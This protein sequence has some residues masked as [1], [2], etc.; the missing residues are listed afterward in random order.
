MEHARGWRL[1]LW[2]P[3]DTR[4]IVIVALAN[5]AL[6]HRPFYG[7]AVAHLDLS[8]ANGLLTLAAVIFLLVFAT[9]LFLSLVS[10]V[11]PALVRPACMLGAFGNALALH[12]IESYGAL[13]DKSMMGNVF[14]TDFAEASGLFHPKLLVYL[15]VLGAL[16]CWA[17][18]RVGI[19]RSPLGR[20]AALPVLVLLI[21]V[22]WMYASSRSWLWIDQNARTLGGM[23]L[24]WSYVVNGARH[25][26]ARLAASREQTLLPPASFADDRRTIVVLVIGEAARAQN[27]SLYGY[28]RP[29]NPLTTADG[30]V[31]LPRSRACST[32]TTASVLCILSHADPRRQ[33]A[34]AYEPLPSYL[35]RHGVDVIWRARNWGEPRLEVDTY[36]R[37]RDLRGACRGD[38]C[39][40]DEAL[41]TGLEPRIRSSTKNRIFV[42]LHQK[43][44]HGPSYHAEYPP[45]F[46]AFAPVCRSVDLSRCTTEELVNAYDNTILYTDAFVHGAIEVLRAFPEAATAL[47]YVSDHGESL[48]EYGLYLHGTPWS[49]APD[50]QKDIPFLVWTSDA[51]R[52]KTRISPAQ[53]DPQ[54]GHTHANV[55]HSVMGAFDMRSA[56]YDARLDVFSHDAGA[57]P[58]QP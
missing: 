30:I 24:P 26:M 3:T 4:F 43:G 17:L 5:A 6:Y 20:R 13:L 36:Q 56:I 40:F 51:F 53:L 15:A 22:G 57:P 46:E 39:D 41:L 58:R 38:G 45:R 48:G 8:S 54:D 16:P 32:Y 1:P 23:T 29:T 9:A 55:F 28:R 10:L 42:V 35:H 14:N 2:T 19:R 18:S 44:S 50:V 37:A 34:R 11:A 31:A 12:F 27:F 47:I 21:G 33:L 49:I 25:G 52:L 7:F